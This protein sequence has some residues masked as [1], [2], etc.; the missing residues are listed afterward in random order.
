MLDTVR[1]TQMP[2]LS[3]NIKTRKKQIRPGLALYQTAASAYW[4]ARIWLPAERRYLVRSTKETSRL[5]AEETA[6]E[7]VSELKAGKRLERFPRDRA[8]EFFAEKMLANDEHEFGQSLHRL[9]ARNE[10]SILYRKEDGVLSYLG[11]TDIGS[12]DTQK[13]RDYLKWVDNR[14]PKPLSASTKSKHVNVVR[15]VLTAAYDAKAIASIPRMP[16]VP[17]R[18]NPRSWFDED[19]F[20]GLFLTAREAAERRNKDLRCAPHIGVGAFYPVPRLFIPSANRKRGVCPETPRCPLERD[21]KV[22]QAI[23]G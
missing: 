14:R 7:I 5:A 6:E 15:K 20:E 8:F 16:K 21:A 11:R 23:C 17:R 18:D 9:T 2:K 3:R 12:V 10:R 19:E 22:T 1:H 13:I 4:Y